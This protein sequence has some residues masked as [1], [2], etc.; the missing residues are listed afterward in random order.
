MELPTP[1]LET[2]KVHLLNQPSAATLEVGP[3]DFKGPIL[4]DKL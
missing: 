4:A 2:P 1:A 3:G